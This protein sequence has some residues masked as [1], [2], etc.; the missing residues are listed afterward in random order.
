MAESIQGNN[1]FDSARIP[2][3]QKRGHPQKDESLYHVPSVRPRTPNNL[4][5]TGNA[6]V[7]EHVNPVEDTFSKVGQAVTA[8]VE[9]EI[10][11]G[12]VITGKIGNSDLR[13]VLFK[14]GHYAPVTAENDVAPHL[15]MIRGKETPHATQKRSDARQRRPKES[16]QRRANYL[17]NGSSAHPLA[18]NLLTRRDITATVTAPSVEAR[19]TVVPVVLEPVEAR[20]TVVPV[21]LEPGNAVAEQDALMAAPKGKNM[22]TVTPPTTYKLKLPAPNEKQK[23][24]WH[25]AKSSTQMSTTPNFSLARKKTSG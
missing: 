3:K 18:A 20:R 8:V 7:P 21:V 2:L 23:Y 4:L 19:G 6:S 11:D 17:G 25:G 13:G 5:G 22:Q 14:P 9:S 12:Y 24:C 15:S 16:H 1:S 10:D